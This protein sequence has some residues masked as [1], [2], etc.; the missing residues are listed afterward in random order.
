MK[1]GCGFGN[2]LALIQMGCGMLKYWSDSNPS[3][4]LVV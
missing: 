1:V 4:Y 2:L 3:G